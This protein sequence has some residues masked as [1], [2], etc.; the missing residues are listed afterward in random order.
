MRRF[1]RWQF[2]AVK[3]LFIWHLSNCYAFC[4]WVVCRKAFLSLGP[5]R[6]EVHRVSV[7]I[8]LVHQVY[9]VCYL[10]LALLLLCHLMLPKLLKEIAHAIS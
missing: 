6:L 5:F 4:R 9:G 2:V 1:V 10:M 8:L 3:V 7:G